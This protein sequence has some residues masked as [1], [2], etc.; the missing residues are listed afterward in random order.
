M[1]GCLPCASLP[2]FDE[3]EADPW[4]Q[5]RRAKI[6]SAFGVA[7]ELERRRC[8]E[9]FGFF[10]QR[11]WHTIEPATRYVHG[12][13]IDA[14]VD[15]LTACLPR[16]TYEKVPSLFGG[17]TTERR[18]HP[19]EIRKL[20]INMPP[21]HAKSSLVSVLWPAWVWTFRPDIR[22][23]YTSYALSL[24]IRDTLKMRAVIS[25]PWYQTRFFDSFR[26]LPDQ[27]E[28][29][30][31][32][33]NAMGYR[34]V[35]SPDGGVTGEGGDVVVCFPAETLVRT[36]VGPLPI[37]EIVDGRLPVRVWSRDPSTGLSRLSPV[38]GW[39]RNPGSPLVRVQTP[40]GS[41]RCTP[42]HRIL[43]RSGY[44]RADAL[45]P[46][47]VLPSISIPDPADYCLV[48]AELLCE[49]SGRL[50]GLQNLL[51]VL[52]GDLGHVVLGSDFL[53]RLLESLRVM[54]PGAPVAD[55]CDMSNADAQR[56]CE[57]LC[58]LLSLQDSLNILHSKFGI[59]GLFSCLQPF[60]SDC[61]S[62]VV[63]PGSVGEVLDVVVH[64]VSVQVSRVL[65]C[66]SL[67][68]ECFGDELVNEALERLSSLAHADAPV[69]LGD[70][71]FKQ[72]SR[73]P[74]RLAVS[75]RDP[76]DASRIS[77]AGDHVE[78]LE[79]GDISP[80]FVS[81]FGHCD[82]S[83][84]LTVESDH[85]FILCVGGDNIVV[86]NCDDPHNVR[87]ADSEAKRE[88][89]N[90]WWFE[91]M[92]SRLNDAQTGSFIVTMQRVHEK[93]LSARCLE[94]GYVHLNLPARYD[95]SRSCV[96][97]LGWKDWRTT[98]GELLWPERFPEQTLSDLERTLGEYATN[99]QLQQNPRPRGGAFIMRDW[100]KRTTPAALN[101][102]G[103]ISWGRSWDLSLSKEGDRVASVDYGVGPEGEV[104]LRRGLYWR[105]DW[106]VSLKRIEMVQKNERGRVLFECIGT[107]KSAG[108]EA[109]KAAGGWS[110]VDKLE[111]KENKVSM[112][113]P[114]IALAQAGKIYLVEESEE[115]WP[116]FSFN[117]GSWIEHFLNQFAKWVP[118]P[119][120][121]QEDDEVDAVSLCQFKYGSNVPLDKVLMPGA[122]D[123]A[124]SFL[125]PT[126]LPGG[127][128]M[129]GDDFEFDDMDEPMNDFSN[130][131][132]GLM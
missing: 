62:D 79:P 51:D 42:D 12:R 73:Y 15:H 34:M 46:S 93:D 74:E 14:I 33:N 132:G 65:S 126:P 47:D 64:R 50:A 30:K 52:L 5:E 45:R 115:E 84:C 61:I 11:A 80:L 92:A 94:H 3:F 87:D 19:G 6:E 49:C 98:D 88:G 72:P 107:T 70:I 117:S 53:V 21:R 13:H 118:D 95:S 60:G 116:L 22:W 4:E 104:Y 28:K 18:V 25:S 101:M 96:T 57:L 66:L 59:R 39:H 9:D 69:P 100:F 67:P 40:S 90:T 113:M 7:I 68:D 44:V 110:V 38:T 56:R 128:G 58:S 23:F 81:R 111:S 99:S 55:R 37:G 78:P 31:F 27:N 20:L 41:F 121:S 89:T 119:T 76:W 26:M 63:A 129:D 91:S 122:I 85:N 114:W 103:S 112:A 127:T 131:T 2:V 17:E 43:T 75:T 130:Y 97:S 83:Y 10:A 125:D 29:M 124:S 77:L 35:G 102:I 48:D 16:V 123:G 32:Y 8:K 108:E 54:P 24:A 106:P 120:L 1:S 109:A 36:E 71:Q 105:A 82:T 86:S